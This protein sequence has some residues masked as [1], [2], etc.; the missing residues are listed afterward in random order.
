M[1]NKAD[2]GI[3]EAGAQGRRGHDIRL[4]EGGE[5][6]SKQLLL[7]LGR[8]CVGCVLGAVEQLGERGSVLL[9]PDVEDDLVPGLVK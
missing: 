6:C 9:R 5:P 8:A 7:L 1:D 4:V 3:V 2:V